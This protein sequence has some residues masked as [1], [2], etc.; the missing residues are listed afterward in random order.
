[1]EAPAHVRHSG[2]VAGLI[3]GG[4]GRIGGQREIRAAPLNWS[5]CMV[6]LSASAAAAVAVARRERT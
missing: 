2:F 6:G 1:M 3:D 4:H 5:P